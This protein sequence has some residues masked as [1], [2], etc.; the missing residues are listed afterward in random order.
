[1]EFIGPIAGSLIPL[2]PEF[3]QDICQLPRKDGIDLILAITC[4]AISLSALFSSQKVFGYDI[5]IYKKEA[6]EGINK[7]SYFFAKLTAHVPAQMF[8]TFL[9]SVIWFSFIVPRA[10]YISYFGLFLLIEWVFSGFGILMSLLFNKDRSIFLGL[11][12]ILFN[13]S[14]SGYLPTLAQLEKYWFS[15]ILA[16]AFPM[17]WC[18]EPLY[19]LEIDIYREDGVDVS[20][21]LKYHGFKRLNEG[22]IYLDIV[23]MFLFGILYRILSFLILVYIDPTIR[24]RVKIL[25]RGTL[26][27]VFKMLKNCC[28]KKKKKDQSKDKELQESLLLQDDENENDHQYEK[29]KNDGEVKEFDK[30]LLESDDSDDDIFEEDIPVDDEDD[31]EDELLF[32]H[33]E[34]GHMLILQDDDDDDEIILKNYEEEESKEE[35]VSQDENKEKNE[36]ILEDEEE[37]E[38]IIIIKDENKKSQKEQNL[39]ILDDDDDE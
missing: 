28:K 23:I 16:N 5:P 33:N 34:D 7:L 6:K 1:M 31:G 26:R 39:I 4:L 14:L 13:F 17:R 8:L 32:I 22:Q 36:N 15:A 2:C 37:D 19:I 12:F 11:C 20:S 25:T 21:A 35:N 3:I 24:S 38:E 18:F 30:K 27:K 10:N 9:F 29:V